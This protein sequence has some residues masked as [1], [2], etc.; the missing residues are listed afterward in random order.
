[1]VPGLIGR[2]QINCI[3]ELLVAYKVTL[4]AE[5]LTRRD[6]GSISRSLSRLF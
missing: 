6:Y 4:Y 1:M 2:A 5:D 3:D